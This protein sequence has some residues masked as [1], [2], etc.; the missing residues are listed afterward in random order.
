M[1]RMEIVID[2]RKT[3]N[4]YYDKELKHIA[5]NNDIIK[6]NNNDGASAFNIVIDVLA[7]S[8]KL[9]EQERNVLYIINYYNQ[10]KDVN[11]ILDIYKSNYNR[12]RTTFNRAIDT[13]EKK[14]VIKVDNRGLIKINK[15]YV[16]NN[17]TSAKAKFLVVEINPKVT[18]KTI[19][20]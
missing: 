12:S 19:D 1:E 18:S 13:L 6:F 8:L 2:T 11:T 3:D 20:I 5:N 16:I 10:I 17:N 7:S 4:H 9:N 14:R 15:S